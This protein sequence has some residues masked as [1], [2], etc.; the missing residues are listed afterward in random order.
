MSRAL[1]CQKAHETNRH[2]VSFDTGIGGSYERSLAIFFQNLFCSLLKVPISYP[3]A[4]TPLL[5]DLHGR[6]WKKR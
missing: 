5:E 3:L 4:A 6:H 1:L 2:F